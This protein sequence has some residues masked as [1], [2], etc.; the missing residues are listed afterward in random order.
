MTEPEVRLRPGRERPFLGRH[1]WVFAGA[2][3]GVRGEPEDGDE[4]LLRTA[5]GTFLARGLWNSQSQIRVR[6][7]TWREAERLDADFW[8][9]RLGEALD[10]R[11]ALPGVDFARGPLRLVFSEGDGLSGL[12]VDRYGDWLVVQ[13]TSLALARRLDL[14]LDLLEE[15]LPARG[16]Y[17]RTERGIGEEEGLV[18]EDGLLRGA[19]PDG[20]HEVEESGLRMAVD[21]RTG[22]KTGFYMDQRENRRRA[23]RYAEGRSAVDLFCYTGGFA[24]ALARA[25][26]AGVIGIDGSAGAVELARANAETNGL[27]D[28]T[29]FLE[30]DAF[31]W[32]EEAV[33]TDERFGLIVL[34]PPRFARSRRGVPAAL[35]AYTA[36]NELAARVLEPSGILVTFSCSGR[37]SREDFQ[38]TLQGAA[39]RT[40]R[41]VQILE[42]LGQPGDHPVSVSCPETAYLKGFVCRVT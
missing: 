3:G 1:P 9:T 12:V 23:A 5:D 42:S 31:R 21:L 34:D 39:E 27:A 32:L 14:L 7:Y 28:Q 25:G 13:V 38:A 6:L 29:A 37:V 15:A 24:L 40:G 17:L 41:A 33:A 16:I 36:L 2:V 4:V 22:Q 30:G 8:R 19:A 35:R 11:R 26:A 20:L 18:L 10:L